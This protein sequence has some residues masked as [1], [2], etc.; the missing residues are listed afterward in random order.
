MDTEELV[1]TVTNTSL[2]TYFT[3]FT[4]RSRSHLAQ[5]PGN[6]KQKRPEKILGP[7][8]NL[9]PTY[10]CWINT[11]VKLSDPIFKLKMDQMGTGEITTVR[12]L[13]S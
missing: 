12:M 4:P 7:P 6:L 3:T 9:G 5:G 11:G 2:N 1:R 13:P 10:C 8:P